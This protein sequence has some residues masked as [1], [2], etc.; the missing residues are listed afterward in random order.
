MADSI[1]KMIAV[2]GDKVRAMKAAKAPKEE[3]DVEIARLKAFK[4]ELASVTDE[5]VEGGPAAKEKTKI[6][7]VGADTAGGAGQRQQE[8]PLEPV[9][10]K[11]AAKNAEKQRAKMEKFAAKQAALAAAKAAKE[12][13]KGEH[14]NDKK[15]GKAASAEEVFVNRTPKGEKKDLS[16]PMAPSYNPVAVEAAWYDWWEEQNYFKP[17]LTEDGKPLPGGTFVIAMPPPNVTGHLHIGHALTTAIQDCLVRWYVTF[18]GVI[19]GQGGWG[20]GGG[21]NARRRA[22]EERGWEQ[23]AVS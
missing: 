8:Q 2:Q 14:G 10:G 6:A 18:T 21:K 22:M 9:A 12:A 11:N 20:G 16:Q 15:K 23:D 19:A 13:N 5:Q 4:F 7:E 17:E 3:L 1:R